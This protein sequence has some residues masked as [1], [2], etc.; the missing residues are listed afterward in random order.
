[1]QKFKLNDYIEKLKEK[2]LFIEENIND[3]LKNK[4]INLLTYD[5]REAKE[6]TLFVC[7]GI[8]FKKEFLDSA[9]AQGI[10]AYVS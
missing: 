6:N 7:K 4:E 1:M 9:L 3:E 8:H 10:T 5:S 2:K